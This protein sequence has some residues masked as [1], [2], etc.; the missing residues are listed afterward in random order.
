MNG[1]GIFILC[2]LDGRLEEEKEKEPE[3]GGVFVETFKKVSGGCDAPNKIDLC[4]T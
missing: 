3:K 4:M 1:V 2:L